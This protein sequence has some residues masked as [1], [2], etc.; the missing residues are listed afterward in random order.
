[1]HE[2]QE[3]KASEE[4]EWAKFN[5]RTLRR[6]V[7]KNHTTTAAQVTEKLNI[8]LVYPVST[9][10]VRRELHKSSIHGMAANAKSLVIENYAFVAGSPYPQTHSPTL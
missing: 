7:S 4:K 8:H 9:K 5:R 6:F 1:M 10:P 2:S 3:G